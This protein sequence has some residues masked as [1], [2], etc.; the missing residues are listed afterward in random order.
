M[1]DPRIFPI[2][3]S[4]PTATVAPAVSGVVLAANER[5]V[6]AEIVNVSDP[7]EMISLSRGGV[8]VLG[9]GIT[10]TTYGSSYRIG[11][12][13]LFLGDINGISASGNAAL[14]VDEGNR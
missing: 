12:A 3:R 8:A 14:S 10:L 5:R 2:D 7:A 11:T 4:I 13:N 1:P 6:D 9:A